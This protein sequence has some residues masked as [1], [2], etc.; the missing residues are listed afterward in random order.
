MADHEPLRIEWQIATPWCPPALG[1]HLDGLLAWATIRE[2][3]REVCEVTADDSLLAN[4]PFA[5]SESESGWVW[6]ASLVEPHGV[7]GSERRYMTAKTASQ[8][9]AERMNDGR[10]VGK[11]L[12]EIDTVRGP[13]KNDAF[14][15][16]VQDIDSCVAWCIGDPAR[17]TELLGQVHNLGKRG[18]LDHG[19][20]AD[21]K[22]IEDEDAT[23]RWRRRNMP[24]PQEGYAPSVGR[25]RPWY[26]EGEGATQI[27][28]PL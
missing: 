1:M 19:R 2:A 20:I 10:I 9:F 23:M 15:Y 13:Y 26:W 22:V 6:K 12:T 7:R 16:T 5:K 18:R 4:L 3:G 14:W 11:P 24:E 27:W 17:I 28:K 21:F 25:L 8:E